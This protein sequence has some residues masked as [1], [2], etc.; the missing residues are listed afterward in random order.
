MST[1]R[2]K[3]PEE[4]KQEAVKLAM[5]LGNTSEAARQLGISDGIL[6]VWK[7]KFAGQDQAVHENQSAE[8]VALE[9]QRLRKE[10]EELKKINLILKT[11]AAFFSQ[12]HLK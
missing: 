9:M 10:N 2:R 12:D 7:A 11:A 1:N 8:P 4:F 3:Y 6:S 5:S